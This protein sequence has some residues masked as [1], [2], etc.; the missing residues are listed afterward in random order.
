MSKQRWRARWCEA[1]RQR[2][3]VFESERSLVVARIDF[4]LQCVFREW[5]LPQTFELEEVG[6]GETRGPEKR[7]AG[8]VFNPHARHAPIELQFIVLHVEHKD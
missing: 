5:A 3:L 2:E 7:T 1:G 6:N 8:A 4:L